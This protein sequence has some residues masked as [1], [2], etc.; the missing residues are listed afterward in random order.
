MQ[1][2]TLGIILSNVKLG[3]KKVISK[4]YTL[5]SGLQS[6]AINFGTSSKSKIR[7]AHIQPM[8]ILELETTSKEN[9]EVKRINEIRLARPC[10]E[11]QTNILK[12]CIAGFINEL[13]IKT[14]KETESSEEMF[15]FICDKIYEL[16]ETKNNLS[17]WPLHFMMGLTLQL[18]IMPNNNF[19]GEKIFFNLMDGRFDETPPVHMNYFDRND[20]KIF[21]NLI[22]NFESYTQNP[23]D[24]YERQSM[25][26]LLVEYY[27]FHIPG[28]G[29]FKSLPVLQ[30][31]LHG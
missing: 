1:I 9:N 7:P 5:S 13:L 15:N 18:G 12:S 22:Q 19:D 23:P 29:E 30:A 14:L 6:F 16:N 4:I 31:T 2:K 21:R 20:S 24:N 10:I 26:N 8:N 3:D 17:G 11:I 28:F 25:L 27:R